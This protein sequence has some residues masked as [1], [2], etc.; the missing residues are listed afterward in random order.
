MSYRLDLTG[1]LIQILFKLARRPHSKLTQS[2]EVLNLLSRVTIAADLAERRHLGWDA[3][4]IQF[5][6]DLRQEA[7]G[8]V[9]D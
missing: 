7:Y 5:R 1:R 2:E 9:S 6:R 3:A 8:G 4:F